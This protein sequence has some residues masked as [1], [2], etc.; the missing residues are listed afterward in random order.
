MMHLLFLNPVGVIGGAERVLLS[1]VNAV[2][3]LR[4]MWRVSAILLHRGPL[5]ERLADLGVDVHVVALPPAFSGLGDTQLR[6]GKTAIRLWQLAW[7][8]LKFAPSGWTFLRRL[9]RIVRD[10]NPTL[11]HSNGMKTHLFA[12]LAGLS[13]VPVVWHL[14]DFYSQRPVMA[15]VLRR[16][17]RNVIGAVAVSEAVD[18]DAKTVLPELTT[19]VV[20]NA[21]DTN[22]FVPAFT[23][24]AE[25]DR[26]AG[27]ATAPKDVTR[28]GLVATYGNW[29]GQDVFLDAVA[30]LP[31]EPPIR[32][33]I[34]GGP[35]YATAGSQF[36]LSELRSRASALGI[37]QRVG[38]VPFQPDP[39]A[40]YRM[41]DVVVHASVRPE[42]FGLTITE[43]MACGRA[44][45]VSRAGGA[46]ELFTPNYDGIGHEP[47]DASELAEAIQRLVA[48]PDLRK[49]LG[50]N[51]RTTAERKFNLNRFSEELISFYE[52]LTLPLRPTPPLG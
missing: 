20:R 19:T 23:R 43:A 31:H 3:R 35:I 24:S 10:L 41:L 8:T 15:K 22:H 40:I 13:S 47:G 49:C 48:D 9:R 44:I 16:I 29:K 32:A 33:Y 6:A 5:E 1:A 18:S 38:F 45:I 26:L 25:L 52:R 2:R 28:V 12:H 51:A 42:P 11:I 39:L 7:T 37:Q 14:H 46:A 30:K 21:V 50:T 36:T 4:P 27:F 17:S 34:V